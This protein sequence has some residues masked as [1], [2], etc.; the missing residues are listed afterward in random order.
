MVSSLRRS[1]EKILSYFHDLNK[2][3]FSNSELYGIFI[4]NRDEWSLVK[5]TS[6]KKFLEL[7][8]ERQVLEEIKLSFPRKRVIRY[9]N[10]QTSP[11]ELALSLNEDAYLS[12]HSA[13]FLHGLTD[14]VPKNIFVNSE[15]SPKRSKGSELLQERI[16]RAFK[17]P[18]RITTN[19]ATYNE[20]T[21]W[22]LNGKNTGSY[23]VIEIIKDN[24]KLSVTDIERTLVDIAVRPQYSGGMFEVLKAYKFAKDKISVAKLYETLKK[25][26]YVYPYHQV[27][28]FYLEKVGIDDRLL[29]PF[30][31]M[32][33]EFD[34][35]LGHQIED[36]AYSNR[37][38]LYY[39][40][41]L[42]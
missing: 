23:G 14:T 31:E 35:Y 15:Q 24:S 16:D 39:P 33:L 5:S 42:S 10:S 41:N 1:S 26:N 28:G 8:H 37:W 17:N 6:F 25:L 38:R 21:I 7:L 2:G 11:Y 4:N 30:I 32:G 12:H 29:E 40:N 20:Y 3:V 19:I 18:A 9:I 27:V 36:I 13:T 34:F 22:H